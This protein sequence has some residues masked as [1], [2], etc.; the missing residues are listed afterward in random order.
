M[1]IV[2]P[3]P[4][5]DQGSLER[6]TNHDP[7]VRYDACLLDGD[8]AFCWGDA[9]AVQRASNFSGR[10]ASVAVIGPEGG[11][12]REL[13][14]WVAGGA[15]FESLR[16]VTVDAWLEPELKR[17]FHVEG[18]GDWD[19]MMSELSPAR[20]RQED[21]LVS[22]DDHRDAEEIEKLNTE[23][24]PTAESEPGTGKSIHWLGHRA[25][26]RLVAA[27]AVHLS[28]TGHGVLCGIVVHPDFRGQGLGGAITAGLTRYCVERDGLATLGVYR[29]N[30]VA[31]GLYGRLGYRTI[32][33]FS[34]RRVTRR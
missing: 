27:G 30:S 8:T 29:S 34:S 21:V 24:S 15:G 19:W 5:R 26:G 11:A 17:Q 25:G 6:A 32:H 16:A 31:I 10:P 14:A 23:A 3:T 33:R 18:G 28:D 22:L 2:E 12:A 20:H 9:V 13:L 4:L 7:Y 1:T